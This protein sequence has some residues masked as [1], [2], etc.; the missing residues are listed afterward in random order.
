[1]RKKLSRLTVCFLLAA[2]CL[3]ATGADGFAQQ[4]T[5]G[6]R[7]SVRDING[8]IPG[9]TVTVTNEDTNVPRDTVSNEVGEYNFPALPPATYSIKT[10]LQGYNTFERRGLR[11]A[12]QQFVT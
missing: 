12:T 4:F 2:G 6:I 1:M 9:V 7:G 11:I 3:L 8:V 10:S 5:G